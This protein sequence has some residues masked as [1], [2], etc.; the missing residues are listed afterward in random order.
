MYSDYIVSRLTDF[1][2]KLD[3]TG[4]VSKS[5]CLSLESTTG[6]DI[7]SKSKVINLTS[8]SVTTAG[9]I[10]V[11]KSVDDVLAT[12]KTYLAKNIK[13]PDDYYSALHVLIKTLTNAI[14][15]LEGFR[16][17]SPI[18]RDKVLNK[19]FAL[20]YVDDKLVNLLEEPDL[21]EVFN[22]VNFITAVARDINPETAE[23]KI[24]TIA[25]VMQHDIP[26]VIGEHN[27]TI[28]PF[29]SKLVDIVNLDTSKDRKE[30]TKIH[31][32][33]S[34]NTITLPVLVNTIFLI[35]KVIDELNTL[36]K[37]YVYFLSVNTDMESIENNNYYYDEAVALTNIYAIT[38]ETKSLDA[39]ILYMFNTLVKL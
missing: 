23:D 37:Q 7:F 1:K 28:H 34:I 2:T 38:K 16:G 24:S 15:Y 17:L 26:Q 29:I 35:N 18:I 5:E 39:H 21:L 3:T 32:A 27:A 4:L 6:L 33:P 14:S 19:G 12:A 10:E 13:T 25:S 36:K 11:K 30:I 31:L 22:N 9:I 8:E 20:Q